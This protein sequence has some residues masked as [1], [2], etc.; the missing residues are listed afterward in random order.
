MSELRV[1]MLSDMYPPVIGGLER[2]VQALARELVRRGHHVAVAT[3]AIP[4][5]PP[6][7]VDDGVRVHRI[8]GWS[9][10]FRRFYEDPGKPFHPTAPDPGMVA[11]LRRIVREERPHVVHSHAWQLF[12]YLPL[13]RR[14]GPALVATMHD[15]GL[16]CATKTFV[17][18]GADCTGPALAKCLRCARGQ[19]GAPRGGALTVGLRLSRPLLRRVDRLIA[20]SAAVGG[21]VADVLGPSG[22]PVDVIPNFISEA[23]VAQASNGAVRPGFLPAADDYVLFVGALGPHK[24]L[25][26]LLRAH[27][28]LPHGVRSVLLGTPRADSPTRYPDGVTVRLDVPHGEVM[29]AWRH[30]AVGVV[31]S[32]CQE[33]CPT[34]ALEAM[35][36]GKPV[37]ASA[38]GGLKEIVVDGE[39]GLLVPANDVDALHG[40]IARLL[41]DEQLRRR[42]GEAA[43]ERAHGYTLGVIASRVEAAYR[44]TLAGAGGTRPDG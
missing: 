23:L 44:E 32:I 29:Q 15:F 6:F 3:Q 7:E 2:H 27:E 10:A 18:E 20:V 21:P 17:Y 14:G 33:A 11:G 41:A 24:G 13:A 40:A 25:D 5:A 31:P 1:L 9:R 37:V 22:P 4:D 43:R 36:S 8:G 19:Y 12:S 42:M 16:V 38:I 34:V 35:A 28:R 39:T 26:V 30:C